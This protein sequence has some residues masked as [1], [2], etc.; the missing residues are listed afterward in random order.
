VLHL[1][2]MPE[3]AISQRLI[4]LSP[5]AGDDVR[6]EEEASRLPG[7][8]GRRVTLL[9]NGKLMADVFLQ[10]LGGIL[11]ERYDVEIAFALKPDMSRVAPR[12]L[13]DQ[14]AAGSHAI[15]TGV[16]D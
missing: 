15:I 13:L 3:E 16:G 7:L 9:S 11:R 2:A 12:G 5:V 10:E 8:E 14:L 6:T 1:K 4:V